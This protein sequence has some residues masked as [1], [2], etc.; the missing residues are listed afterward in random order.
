M[1]PEFLIPYRAADGTSFRF[2]FRWQIMVGCR[3]LCIVWNR[4]RLLSHSRCAAVDYP[5][6]K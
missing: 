3:L 5:E 4:L 6:W 2:A 1:G